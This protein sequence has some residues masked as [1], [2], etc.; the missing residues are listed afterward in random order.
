MLK[1]APTDAMVETDDHG[2]V[3]INRESTQIDSQAIHPSLTSCAGT[4]QQRTFGTWS[5]IR[6]SPPSNLRPKGP[7]LLSEQAASKIL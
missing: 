1:E 7:S 3:D 6:C 5:A 2:A 4:D